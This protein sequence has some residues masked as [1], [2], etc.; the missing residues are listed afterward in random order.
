[1]PAS[2]R[3]SALGSSAILG[4]MRSELPAGTVTFLFTDVESSTQLLHELGADRYA[5][6][7]AEHR[8]VIRDAVARHGGVE[9]DTQGDAFFVA[10]ATAPRALQAAADAQ[11]AFGAQTLKVRMGLHTGTP[12]LTDEGY[13]GADVH[14]AARI[15]AAGHGGQVLVSAATASLV[16]SSDGLPLV[17]LGLHRLKDLSAPERISQ[18]GEREF[19]ALKSLHR[20]NLPTPATPFLGRENERA[21]LAGL[22]GRTRLLTLTGPGGTGKTRLGL[23]AVADAAERYP[24]GLF[25]VPLAPLRDPE[26]VLD[27]ASRA[28]GAR[29]SLGDY[30]GDKSLLLLFDNFEHVLEAATGLGQL[31]AECPRLQLVV[32]SRELLRLPGEQAYP[33]PPLEPDD[34]A[35]LFL[36]RARATR[37]DFGDSA[38]VGEL[39]TRLDNLPLALELAAARVR[40]LTPAQLL[41]RLS[42]RLDLLTGAR[43]VDPRQQ[44]LRATIEWSYELL[45]ESERRLFARLSVFHGSWSLE[46]AEAICEA[47]VGTLE[48][49]VDKSLVLVR[50]ENRFWMLET[51]REYAVGLLAESGEGD[52]LRR[53]HAHHFLDLAE[54]VEPELHGGRQGEWLERLEHD[55]PNLRAALEWSASSDDG[56]GLRLAT[57]LWQLWIKHGH[58]REGRRW[59]KEFL[60]DPTAEGRVRARAFAGLAVLATLVGDWPEAERRAEEALRL[61]DELG[62][63]SLGAWARVALGRATLAAGDHERARGLFRE[64]E[65]L[66]LMEDEVETVAVA[67]FNLGYDSLSGGDYDDARHWFETALS[68]LMADSEGYWVARTLAALG[69]VALHQGRTEDAIGFLRRS[70]GV[71]S[72]TG[73]RDNM[74]WAIQLLGVAYAHDRPTVAARLLGAADALREELGGTLEGVELLLHEGA[75]TELHEALAPE[76]LAAEWAAGRAT[77]PERVVADYVTT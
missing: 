67:R 47:G 7:L 29:G 1:M 65:A 48:S 44:T 32:T 51:I 73:D 70:L 11:E 27:A 49:L 15:A 14:R 74:A 38:A 52:E 6:A 36:A 50:E 21:E 41:A 57:A 54:S 30:I 37:P 28:L 40:V 25:W 13:V 68:G 77:P 63:P 26:L 8:R 46:A 20:T 5:E 34:G 45:D 2:P 58:I 69:S 18:L 72:R 3:F 71:S 12:L 64:A 60:A 17:D 31:L 22:L 66:G 16:G 33:V 39:C 42:Q 24:D 4:G 53:R 59:L 9:V 75:L 76:L 56:L 62:D 19:P 61:S 23:Q 43:G 35:E 55:L 10:F